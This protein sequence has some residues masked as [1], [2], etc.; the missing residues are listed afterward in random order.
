MRITLDK[1]ITLSEYV[2]SFLLVCSL[3]HSF[4][5]CKLV[6]YYVPSTYMRYSNEQKGQKYLTSCSL[7]SSWG[8]G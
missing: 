6:V 7:N 4:N 3:I 1:I 5:P 8:L 2:S